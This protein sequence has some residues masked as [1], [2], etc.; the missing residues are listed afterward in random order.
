VGLVNG[1]MIFNCSMIDPGH[2]CVTM[3]GSALSCFDPT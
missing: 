1:S 2:P 3:I